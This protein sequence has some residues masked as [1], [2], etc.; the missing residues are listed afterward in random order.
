MFIV[1]M[2]L[3]Y[4]IYSGARDATQSTERVVM[5]QQYPEKGKLA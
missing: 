1:L 4:L 5:S 3:K 2:G